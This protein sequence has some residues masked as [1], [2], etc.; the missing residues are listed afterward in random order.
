M[1][2]D[3]LKEHSFSR[4]NASEAI[5]E[6]FE[7]AA[8]P[9]IF[10]FFISL[11]MLYTENFADKILANSVT[12]FLQLTG[13]K[14]TLYSSLITTGLSLIIIKITSIRKFLNWVTASICKCGFSFTG[15]IVGVFIGLAIPAGINSQSLKVV[16]GF[17]LIAIWFAALQ[18]LYYWIAQIGNNGINDPDRKVFGFT[19]MNLAPWFGAILITL[20]L[21]G[22]LTDTWPEV[23]GA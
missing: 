2:I 4:M 9:A 14:I 19:V 17:I 11:S 7:L 16:L 22:V 5:R 15:I 21:I 6:T 1:R 20:S 13:I 23:F 10:C 12:E 3:I 8:M 18:A